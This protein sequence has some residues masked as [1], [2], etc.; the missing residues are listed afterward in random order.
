MVGPPAASKPA[1]Q[2]A[3]K[4]KNTPT[5]HLSPPQRIQLA[6]GRRDLRAQLLLLARRFAVLVGSPRFALWPWDPSWV[7]SFEE[8]TVVFVE[9][10]LSAKPLWK[11][12]SLK[13]VWG[14]SSPLFRKNRK[15]R[16]MGE[17]K[18][19]RQKKTDT[20]AF[21]YGAP[22]PN[23]LRP[24]RRFGARAR[25]LARGSASWSRSLWASKVS[26]AARGS[27]ASGS[28][29]SWRRIEPKGTDPRGTTNQRGRTKGDGPKGDGPKKKRR[30]Q[31]KAREREAKLKAKGENKEATGEP[32]E[33]FKGKNPKD[34]EM[35][36]LFQV[37]DVLGKWKEG[38]RRLHLDFPPPPIWWVGCWEKRR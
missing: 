13:H 37:L 24:P 4:Q 36:W 33:N 3:T 25:A 26:K 9:P 5:P 32:K 28:R 1:W 14:F 38:S 10:N 34:M 23:K 11:S 6:P 12:N 21:F 27:E 17:K 8:P 15:R 16:N 29:A 2:K 19:E 18:K 22:E 30:D 31:C 35:P 7:R 20:S